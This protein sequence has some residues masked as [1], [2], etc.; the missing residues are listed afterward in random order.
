MADRGKTIE[1]NP[2]HL[3]FDINDYD[4]LKKTTKHF[5]NEIGKGPF[6]SSLY[7]GILED[8]RTITVMKLAENAPLSDDVYTRFKN[9]VKILMEREHENVVKVFGYCHETIKKSVESNGRHMFADITE[10]L[11]C[12]EYFSTGSV[13]NLVAKTSNIDWGKRFNIVKGI[14]HGLHY[15]HSSS[16]FHMDLNPQNIWLDDNM[17]PKIANFGFAIL[18]LFGQEKFRMNKI[19]DVGSVGYMA[20][21]FRYYGEISA[22]APL[23][24]YSLGLII[25]EIATGE[26]HCGSEDRDARKFVDQVR[27]DWTK[28]VIMFEYPDLDLDGRG[29]V[30]TCIDIGLQCLEIDQKKRPS[31]EKVLSMLNGRDLP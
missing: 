6:G 23:D 17:V 8:G 19:S 14:C 31:I 10:T 21:E 28:D 1:S 11:L 15:L 24:I 9:G 26:N 3:P 16:I 20:P 13:Q 29:Q 12:Y 18:E 22:P 4:Y 7:K 25:I 5:S 30:K 27:Q 2:S